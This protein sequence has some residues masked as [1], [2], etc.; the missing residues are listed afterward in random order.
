MFAAM[1]LYPCS[2]FQSYTKLCTYA[3]VLVTKYQKQISGPLLDR[4]DMH[5]QVP[6]V[7]YEKLSSDRL[8]ETS[9]SIR[10]RVRAARDIQT[11]QFVDYSSEI[12]CNADMHVGEI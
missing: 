2:Y 12:M 3:P 9:V 4:I 5:I 11:R 6:R 7:D 10:A 1:K 8:E